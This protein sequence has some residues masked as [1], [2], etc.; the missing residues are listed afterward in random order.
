MWV[1]PGVEVEQD[2]SEH[3]LKLAVGVIPRRPFSPF[4]GSLASS[5]VFLNPVVS[6]DVLRQ[7][8]IPEQLQLLR[9]LGWETFVNGAFEVT[10]SIRSNE[11]RAARA[12]LSKADF[13]ARGAPGYQGPGWARFGSGRAVLQLSLN[14]A[15]E[16]VTVA[17]HL[18][19][20]SVDVEVVQASHAAER[21]QEVLNA[22]G[23]ADLDSLALLFDPLGP[24]RFVQRPQHHD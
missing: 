2:E 22:V 12:S 19:R 3:W 8:G 15:G 1:R 17:D 6:V 10:A 11:Q 23:V 21:G 18:S 9:R 13:Q 20:S 24:G 14:L 16:V 7:I 4:A 5:I